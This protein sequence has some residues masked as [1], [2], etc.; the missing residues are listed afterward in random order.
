M[1]PLFTEEEE[2]DVVSVG[3]GRILPTNPS[4]RDRRA[5][6]TTV[7]HKI[8]ARMVKT[9]KNGLRTIPPRRRH[10][11]EDLSS[12]GSSSSSTPTKHFIGNGHSYY[13]STNSSGTVTPHQ[14]GAGTITGHHHSI[15]RKRPYT[16]VSMTNQQ[17][18]GTAGGGSSKKYRG[19]KYA[20]QQQNAAAA[21]AAARRQISDSDDAD[22]QEKRNLH[23]DM[24]RQRRIGLK[25]L[26]EEL[27]STIP[28]IRDKERAPK[29]NI[30]REATILCTKL[31]RDA[32]QVQVLKKQQARLLARLKQLRA[33]VSNSSSSHFN[34]QLQ[35]NSSTSKR[36]VE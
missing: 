15:S 12:C 10:S 29:V 35:H 5:L 11:N 18:N 14:T 17:S 1:V 9:Q 32:E 6:Q 25:N 33:S 8:S 34:Q 3:A 23:N 22:S 4:A 7:A 36:Y 2:I 27:K 19:K 30:L 31:T 13:T 26:F 28:S 24:E 16:H 20:K 21:A